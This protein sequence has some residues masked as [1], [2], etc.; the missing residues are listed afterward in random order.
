MK[1]EKVAVIGAG[2]MGSGIAAHVANAGF[3]VTLLDIVPE[4]AEN[5]NIITETAVKKMLKP[6][7][8][9]SPTP[10]MH[11]NNSKRI[12]IG[13]IEDNLNL[14][15]DADLIIEVVL[16]K[17]KIKHD[18]FKKID[19]IRKKNS[20][21][22][23]NTSTIPRKLL[24]KGMPKSFSKD[25]MITHF[26]NPP[27]YLRL[28]EIVADKEVDKSKIDLVTKFCDINLGKEVVVCNDTPGFIGNRIGTYWTLIG[29]VEALKLGLTVEEA[30]AIMGRPIGAPKTGIFGLGDVVGLDLIPHVT[31]SMSSNL[32]KSDMYNIGIKEQEKLGIGQILSKMISD[33]YTGRKGKGGFYRLNQ[34][35]GK[36]IKESRN[37]KTGEY[38]KATKKVGLESV[39]AAKKGL[40]SLVKHKDKG[41]EYA[42][43]VLSKTLTYAA[44]L[45]PEITDNI[46]NID[47]AMKNG[48]LWKKGPFEML[49]DLGPSWF[50]SRISDE[51]M[52]IPSLLESVGE[53]TFYQNE[54]DNVKYFETN[55]KYSLLKKPEGYLTVSEVKLGK[56][57][58]F[59]NPSASL[60]DMDDS[61]IL[62][63]FHSKMNS[64]DPL[65]M[66]AL[67]E[68]ADLCEAKKYKGIVIG[69]DGA[70]FSAGANLGL[71]SFVTNVGAWE[72]AEKFVMGG[73]L[74]FMML[75]HGNFP[76]VG[77]SSGLAIG[78]GCEVLLACDAVQAHSESYMGLVE[79]GVGLVPAWGGCKEMIT[80]WNNDP[81]QP[82]GPMA[83]I[84]K[85]FQNVGT[86]KVATSAQE[87]KEMNLLREEDQITM[88]RSRVLYDAKQLCLAM[89]KDYEAPLP[90]EHHLPGPSGK[91]TLDLAVQDLVK[92]GHAT[93]HDIVVTKELSY[94]LCGGDT[95]PT[96]TVSDDKILEMERN[97]IIKLMK[98]EGTMDRVEHM[99]TTGK[100]LRN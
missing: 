12:T 6:V 93:P 60:W 28:L 88:N 82:K 56:Q 65:I 39:K 67:T 74:A 16:E 31:E 97:G 45:V 92:A 22:T 46:V 37:L 24:V 42:W 51:G 68:A 63:E 27:R 86:A 5:R 10:L 71:S 52:K 95:D 15:S 33:G 59:K 87:A 55:G 11:K 50:S 30:D 89:I 64:M 25:F 98:T 94:I 85:I 19:K 9:G 75:K 40:R 53:G 70:N 100:P 61:I 1:I 47:L 57:P 79:V 90:K 18:V 13:N 26:F 54:K 7:K 76:V 35:S 78:G 41:G 3:N 32:P 49:D 99:L 20:I 58:I 72:E 29:M 81:R 4:G 66:E 8:L 34:D 69:N 14:I 62:A 84:T 73:Q 2:V 48:F 36:R 17:L 80:R 21:I 83:N 96:E 77:A 23:S 91:A 44:S 43:K 38:S